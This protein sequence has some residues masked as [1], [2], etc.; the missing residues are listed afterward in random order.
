MQRLQTLQERCFRAQKQL[1]D[2]IPVFHSREKPEW[3]PLSEDERKAIAE[4]LESSGVK[5]AASRFKADHAHWLYEF[6]NV[7][8]YSSA[9]PEG[10]EPDDL[11]FVPP[12]H[13]THIEWY[14]TRGNLILQCRGKDG[15][16]DFEFEEES[17]IPE[18]AKVF[19]PDWLPPG[20]Y[21][22]KAERPKPAQTAKVIK[23]PATPERSLCQRTWPQPDDEDTN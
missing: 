16:R 21:R 14:E 4:A 10:D 5:N 17:D 22:V 8:A 19:D 3:E 9:Y 15:W 12:V 2:E 11:R 6:L 13:A 23:H 20:A 18:D 1:I 7:M